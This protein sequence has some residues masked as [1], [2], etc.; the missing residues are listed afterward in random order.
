MFS[1]GMI[2]VQGILGGWAGAGHLNNRSHEKGAAPCVGLS[3]VEV[4]QSHP[5]SS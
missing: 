3:E 1:E 5:V 4:S 2:A